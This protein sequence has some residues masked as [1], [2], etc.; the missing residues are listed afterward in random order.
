[1][2]QIVKYGS[3]DLEECDR[4]LN[5]MSTG[6]FFKVAE[7]QTQVRVLP[8][9]PGKTTPIL[10][11]NQHRIPIDAEGKVAIFK[12][13]GVGCPA[14][15]AF[16]VHRKSRDAIQRDMAYEVFRPRLRAYINI[17]DRAAEEKGPQ[18]WN[19]GKT[20]VEQI[21]KIRKMNKKIDLT[22]PEKGFDLIIDRVG[23]GKN[24]TKYTIQA[25]RE[26][27]ALGDMSWIESQIDLETIVVELDKQEIEEIVE[28]YLGSFASS[29]ESQP[30]KTIVASQTRRTLPAMK[31]PVAKKKTV[32]D[33]IADADYEEEEEDVRM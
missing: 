1:M 33:D 18:V 8:P 21:L 32:Q 25:D 16:E 12:C 22:N 11:V 2:G 4:Q 17:I 19:A 5:E 23:T 14:C 6:D 15:A 27:S 9:K 13:P 26:N 29:F 7:G 24:D 31:T 30:R 28:T 10:V 20:V 3:F